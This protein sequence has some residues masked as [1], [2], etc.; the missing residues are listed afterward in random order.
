[1]STPRRRVPLLVAIA[2]MACLAPLTGCQ[3]TSNTTSDWRAA[4]PPQIRVGVGD[5]LGN[6][7]FLRQVQ[8]AKAVQFGTAPAYAQ[9]LPD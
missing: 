5:P 4:P 2:P 9:T 3:T 6:A 8:T 7:L 1:M